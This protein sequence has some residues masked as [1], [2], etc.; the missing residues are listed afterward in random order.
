VPPAL[1]KGTT[2]GFS[3]HANF[4]SGTIKRCNGAKQYHTCNKGYE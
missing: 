2:G 4:L 3:E 1:G